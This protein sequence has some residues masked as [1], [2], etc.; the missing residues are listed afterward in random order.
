MTRYQRGIDFPH[1]GFV[2]NAIEDYFKDRG[3]ST[4]REG[5]ADLVCICENNKSKWII[6]AKGETT[7]VGLD[8]RTGLGQLVQRMNEQDANYAI[9]VPETAQFIKQCSVISKWVRVSINIHIIFV[10]IQGNIRIVYPNED[11]A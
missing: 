2:Q 7:A 6:E 10:D 11:M 4:L 5:N 8:F 3:Y 1:E 9:A